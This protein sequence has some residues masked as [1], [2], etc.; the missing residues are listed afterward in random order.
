MRPTCHDENVILINTSDVLEGKVKNHQKVKNTNI[1][2][3]FKKTFRKN[4]ILYSEIRPANKRYAFIDFD[5]TEQYIASTKLMVLR[6]K[7]QIVLP[8]FLLAFL[9]SKPIIAKLQQLAETRSGTFPQITFSSEIAPLPILVPDLK[10]Q[11]HIIDFLGCLDDKIE[12]N[13]KINDTLEKI[14]LAIFRYNFVDYI[15]YGGSSPSEWK[16]VSLNDVC[17]KITDGSHYSPKDSPGSPYPM[18]SVKDMEPY[19]FNHSSCKHITRDEFLKMER[20]DCVPRYND[21]LIAKDGSYLKEIFICSKE[22]KEAILSSIALFRPNLEVVTPEHLLFFLKQPS[23]KKDVGD[24]YVSGS[25]LPRIVLK[26]FKKYTF[27]VPPL[28][29]QLKINPLLN[30]IRMQINANIDEINTLTQIREL[31]LPRLISGELQLPSE[32]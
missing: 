11:E 23:I 1:K 26:D 6:A 2:G 15:P 12:V 3:Q 7:E 31:L 25:A 29:E 16:K 28:S 5:D 10:T 17:V 8:R 24:N 14:A 9:S 4:D 22:K 19:G 18:F 27:V 13:K 21:I 32:I 20:N 30:A